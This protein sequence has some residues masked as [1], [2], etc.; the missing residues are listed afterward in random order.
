MIPSKIKSL[1]DQTVSSLN[2]LMMDEWTQGDEFPTWARTTL[3]EVDYQMNSLRDGLERWQIIDIITDESL[4]NDQK[5][6][7]IIDYFEMRGG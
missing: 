6:D 2:Q 7:A 4:W 5:A 3:V 1:I